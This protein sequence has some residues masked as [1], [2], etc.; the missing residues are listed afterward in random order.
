M[1]PKSILKDTTGS[2]VTIAT[3]KTRDQRNR[4]IAIH[5]ATLLQQQKDAELDILA[6]IEE[7]M[8]YPTSIDADP[9]NPLPADVSRFTSLL[10]SFQPSDYDSLIEERHCADVCGYALCPRKPMKNNSKS[11]LRILGGRGAE[12]DVKFVPSK[13]LELWCSKDCARRALYVKTQ[14]N[15]EPA[16]LRRASAVVQISLLDEKPLHTFTATLPERPKGRVSDD[17]TSNLEKSM[18]DLALERGE[19]SSSVRSKGLLSDDLLENVA[20]SPAVAPS[21]GG[22][23]NHK[24]I[25]G[26]DP[27]VDFDEYLKASRAQDDDEDE[28]WKI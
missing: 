4:D 24:Q 25:E 12:R 9:A 23:S 5:H 11:K 18:S 20:I 1:A 19:Q 3:Q 27:Q 14:L 17:A 7:L 6:A 26:F 13:Q 10:V 22:P 15:E 28:D 8:D 16:W 21:S 2:D